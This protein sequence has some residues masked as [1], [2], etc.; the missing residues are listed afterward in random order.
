M[1]VLEILKNST[2]FLIFNLLF[3]KLSIFK[4]SVCLY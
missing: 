2:Y 3:Y 4:K 1:H